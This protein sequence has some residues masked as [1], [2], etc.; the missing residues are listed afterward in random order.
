MHGCDKHNTQ[1]I[2]VP[3]TTDV[4]VRYSYYFVFHGWMNGHFGRYSSP[5]FHSL[6][7]FLSSSFTQSLTRC[8]IGHHSCTSW[9]CVPRG[10]KVSTA[11]SCLLHVFMCTLDIL[12]FLANFTPLYYV[13]VCIICLFIDL[14]T[15]SFSTVYN[16]EH[17]HGA[18]KPEGAKHLFLSRVTKH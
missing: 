3:L 13:L 7:L 9:K 8:N 4:R 17:I 2:I 6:S 10:S 14:Q 12:D 18:Q 1:M 16:D 5:D 15:S 11:A